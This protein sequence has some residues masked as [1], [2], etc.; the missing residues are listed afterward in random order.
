M[1][2]DCLKNIIEYITGFPNIKVDYIKKECVGFTFNGG[3]YTISPQSL[4]EGIQRIQ[5]EIKSVEGL[6][7]SQ[8]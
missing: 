5:A 6:G 1:E 7:L 4:R 2:T 8:K 3:N